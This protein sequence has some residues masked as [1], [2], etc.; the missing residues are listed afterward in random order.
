MKKLLVFLPAALIII[1]TT[2]A[3]SQKYTTAADTVKLNNDYIKTTNEITKLSSE[4]AIAQ[5]NLPGYQNKAGEAASDAQSTAI[6]S[7]E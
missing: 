4:L 2:S 7:S 3:F 5:N 1:C 6:N